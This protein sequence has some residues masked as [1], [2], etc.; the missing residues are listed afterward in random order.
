[1]DSIWAWVFII[2][3]W[4]VLKA[5]LKSVQSSSGSGG[6]RPTPMGLIE[7]RMI[8]ARLGDDGTGPK[9][10]QL[11]IKGLLPVSKRT[12]VG[13]VTSVFDSTT[14][15]FEP[16]ISAIETL[17]EPHTAIYQ[18]RVQVGYVSP[19]EGFT[20]WV[21]AGFVAPEIIQPPHG[22]RRELSVVLRMVNLDL[23]PDITHGFHDPHHPG[24]LWQT[25]VKFPW[26]FEEKGYQEA[27]A[28][29]EEAMALAVQIGVAIAMADGSLE[30]AE[31]TL[32]KEWVT[33][34]ISPY[35]ENKQAVL[36]DACNRAMKE[37][38]AAAKSGTLAMGP[39]LDRLNV[40]GDKTTKYEAIELCFDVM[41]AD[42]IAH[43][44]ELRRIRAVAEGLGLDIDE[45]NR[46]RDRKIIHLDTNSVHHASVEELLGIQPDWDSAHVKKHL[47]VEFQKWNDRL[48]TLPE[49]NER[50]N[51]QRMLEAISEAR[52][53]HA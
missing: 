2:A 16:I 30:T 32:L 41:A 19:N 17:Q 44:D 4:F 38:Y 35:S 12:K 47:R 5:I 23:I 7:A 9:V 14:G 52:K 25:V 45:I 31:G 48:N 8:D 42:G 6:A 51:A 34:F 15:T 11:E 36:K 21:D 3:G 50:A 22:G 26:T 10:K 43:A 37:A 53:N 39:L 28:H 18:Q 49:G 13:F 24:L 27:A 33:R 40:V 20:D 29:R 1:M 46:M